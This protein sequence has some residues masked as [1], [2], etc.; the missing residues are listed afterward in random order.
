VAGA[1]VPAHLG[2]AGEEL[3]YA[4]ITRLAGEAKPFAA[5]VN[6]DDPSFL[7]PGDMPARIREFCRRT[8]QTPPA[9]RGA[10]VRCALESLA[11]KYRWVIEKLEEL[12]NRPI[13]TV[14]IV[15][16]ARK[17]AAQPV[18]SQRY[19]AHGC[20]R[21]GGGHCHWQHFDGKCWRWARLVSLREAAPLSGALFR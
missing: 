14:H 17:I 4:D 19:G 13:T 1:G 11:F 12:N 15:A 21:P 7:A 20:H 2:A 10:M 18:C 9:D 6:P 5:L 8:G 16:A 3:S